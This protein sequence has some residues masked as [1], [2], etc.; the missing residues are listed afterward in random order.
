M[1]L[2]LKDVAEELSDIQ[3]KDVK[4][5]ALHLNQ[6]SWDT[7]GDIESSSSVNNE[8]VICAV[9][10]WM[11]RDVNASWGQLVSALRKVKQ[12]ALA[13]KIRSRH[14]PDMPADTQP[15]VETF[16][17]ASNDTVSLPSK[18]S[19]AQPR[20]IP[21]VEASMPSTPQLHSFDLSNQTSEHP[22]PA[23][24]SSEE[25]HSPTQSLPHPALAIQP[26]GSLH[27]SDTAAAILDSRIKQVER[28]NCRLKAC[29]ADLRSGTHIYM[30]ERERSS[31]TFL[32]EFRVTLSD[33]PERE[34]HPSEQQVGYYNRLISS[35]DSILDAQN[36]SA[37]FRI[38][39]PYYDYK[40][41]DLLEFII[42]KFGNIQ[43]KERMGGYVLEL[44]TFE[45][46]TTIK[47]FVAATTESTEIP[48]FFK[49]VTIEIKKDASVCTLYDVREFTRSLA[50]KASLTPYALMLQHVGINT[51]VV[52]L[53][54]PRRAL[55][56]LSLAFD[57][58]FQ[59]THC[60]VTVVIDGD[61]FEVYVHVSY[62][63]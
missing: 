24:L 36:V 59:E 56:D 6:M 20:A 41:Y 54:L 47:E 46:K 3:W 11:R 62:F 45:I 21:S 63:L 4:C 35:F 40:N 58:E 19:A 15:A 5:M 52:Q 30:R 17:A 39:R 60:I 25:Q 50:K 26:H 7:L 37:I 23:I 43:L 18:Q 29:F 2:Q 8:R 14:C 32:E 38:I 53:G 61:R 57:E 48:F 10:T 22:T 31:S 42:N 44:E 55:V 13:E 33:L 27:S 16:S 12:N 49:S 1:A 28:E 51:V 34:Q 9:D